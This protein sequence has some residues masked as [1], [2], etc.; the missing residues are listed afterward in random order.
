[1]S[2][3]LSIMWPYLHYNIKKTNPM[4][5]IFDRLYAK[6]HPGK[7]KKANNLSTISA[8]FW[9]DLGKGGNFRKVTNLTL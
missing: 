4:R 6:R 1:M 3:T 7:K 5:H 2:T 8:L 9:F